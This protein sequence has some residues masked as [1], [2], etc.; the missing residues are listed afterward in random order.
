MR[1][2]K[3]FYTVAIMIFGVF[4]IAVTLNFQSFIHAKNMCIQDDKEPLAEKTFLAFNWSVA[5]QE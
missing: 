4:V 5:C 3:K 1:K 2:S